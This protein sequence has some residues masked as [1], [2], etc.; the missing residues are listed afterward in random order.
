MCSR[1][2]SPVGLTLASLVLL[3]VGSLGTP[4]SAQSLTASLAT[5]RGCGAS[6]V[7]NIGESN[8]FLFSVSQ[9]ASVTLRLQRPDGTISTFL[10]N[11]PLQGGV[12]YAINGVIGNPP[13]QRLLT[14]DAVA[15]AQTAHVECTYSAGAAPSTLTATLQTNRGCGAGAVFSIGEPNTFSFSVS[16]S[17]L[18]T[19]RLIR[20]DGTTSTFLANQPVPAGVTQTINGT[21]GNP[22]GQ[23]RLILDA[24]AGT[25]TAHVECDYTAQAVTS[26]LTVNLTTNRGCGA[27]A[28]FNIGEPI[29]FSYSASQD[30][31]V[32]L[33]LQRPDGTSSVLV[34]NQP[35]QGGVTQT[36][37]GII[38][39]PT[40]QR[41]LILDAVAGSQTAHAECTYTAQSTGGGVVVLNLSIDQGCGASY[42][43][44]QGIRINYSAS[45]DATLTLVNQRA[46]G[47][48]QFLFSNQPVLAGQPY[49]LSGIIGSQLGGRTLILTASSGT[50]ASPA[51]CQ[52][53]V[54]P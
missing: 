7:Y 1:F 13:G 20:P 2:N 50:P 28:V 9:N 25:A 10:A 44:G 49:S 14:L 32:T 16:Q 54:V 40:G 30:A 43:V 39:N 53:T 41:T 4:A 24:V 33:R 29:T 51:M 5:D 3:L 52:F 42:H 37:P 21:I 26:A 38:G 35:V 22:P 17:A 45:A 34:A 31:Q 18:V 15:G 46:D 47:T 36:L 48:Q 23:R 11:Q 19:L 27:G 12:T 6:A 8:Q